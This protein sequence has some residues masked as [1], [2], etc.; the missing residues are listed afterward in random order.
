MKR[1]LLGLRA[2]SS[3]TSFTR[4]GHRK[5]FSRKTNKVISLEMLQTECLLSSKEFDRLVK[6]LQNYIMDI[7]KYIESIRAKNF[8]LKNISTN[9]KLLE[10]QSNSGDSSSLKTTFC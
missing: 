8:N 1:L 4:R 7:D 3:N 9:Q 2:H 6:F 10:P 5:S